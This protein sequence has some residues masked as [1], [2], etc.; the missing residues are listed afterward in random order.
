MLSHMQY[1][2]SIDIDA[3]PERVW[4]I[5]ADVERWPEWTESMTTVERTDDGPFGVGSTATVKQP[6]LRPADFVVTTFEP[7]RSFE[8]E[9]K[10]P[11][12][13]SIGDHRV[14]SRAGGG[15]TA[16]LVLKQKGLAA[17][18]IALLFGGLIRRYVKMEA[19]GLK[20]RSEEG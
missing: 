17:P 20:R 7:G 16:T 1:E 9:S 18:L 6:R 10:A 4:E 2:Q 13:T 19:E 15:S 5:L 11:G 3:P 14:E 12:V 8:W